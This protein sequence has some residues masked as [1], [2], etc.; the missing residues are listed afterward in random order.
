MRAYWQMHGIARQVLSAPDQNNSICLES[1]MGKWPKK[2]INTIL[3]NCIFSPFLYNQ[4]R[5]FSARALLL[6]S[7]LLYDPDEHMQIMNK[8]CVATAQFFQQW[9]S[10]SAITSKY[11]KKFGQ[12]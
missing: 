9:R 12:R 6:Y 7:G 1:G 8:T 11:S 10:F 4:G 3:C 5:I 2:D